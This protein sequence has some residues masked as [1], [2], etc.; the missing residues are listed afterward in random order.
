MMVR[1][2]RK[3]PA[4][5]PS[6]RDEI[7]DAAIGVFARKGFID[8]A[9]SD[10]AEAAQ[11]AV[12]AV[13]YHFAGKE[14]LFGAAMTRALAS[15][16][17]VVAAARADDDPGD[18]DALHRVIDAVWEWV[19]ENPEPAMLMYVHSSGAT[20]HTAQ[21]RREF[22]ERHVNRA[23]AY[24]SDPEAHRPEVRQAVATLSLRTLVDSLI[25]VQHLRMVGGPL[26]GR[27]P[28]GLRKAVHALARRIILPI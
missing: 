8:A 5:R 17:A 7:V 6:R 16:D 18:E 9:V 4:H 19:D 12:T 15:V 25:A 23:Y 20:R 11:V 10:V 27:S 26:S 13:Y 1:I 2:V 21:L 3:Q 14:D 28:A 24:L 22:D